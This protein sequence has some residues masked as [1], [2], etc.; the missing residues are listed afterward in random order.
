MA[1]TQD[2]RLMSITTPLGK[3]YLLLNKFDAEEGLSKLFNIEVELLHE[4][5]EAAF[6][7]T[8]VD[9]ASLLGKGVTI[10]VQAPDGATRF[11]TGIFPCRTRSM[12]PAAAVSGVVSLV[13]M[14]KSAAAW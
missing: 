13:S 14:Q 7:P 10:H 9:P 6:L 11:F 1:T 3:D 12:T 4:E 5:T 8:V 2:N